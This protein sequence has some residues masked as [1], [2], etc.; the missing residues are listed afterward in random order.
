[1]TESSDPQAGAPIVARAGTYFR[2][3]RYIIFLMML[4][5]GIA[6]LYDGLVRYPAERERFSHL[7]YE[8]QRAAHAPHTPL[9]ISIQR[10][11]GF[12]LTPLS[13]LLLA[14][15]LYISRGEYRLDGTTLNVPGH[16]PV[17]MENII[18]LNK[19]QWDRKG[20]AVVEYERPGTG[21]GKFVLDDFVYQREPTD[22]IVAQ[23][24]A[25]LQPAAGE[26]GA[27]EDPATVTSPG[28][29]ATE[30]GTM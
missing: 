15:W 18:A 28:E 20:V 29:S 23:I 6:F 25:H 7:S 13:V 9:D 4:G 24:E 17:Q 19:A 16:A 3:A 2:N 30:D 14:R 27:L 1:M 10:L 5:S 8:E 12:S 21:T 26:S 11:L 22:K